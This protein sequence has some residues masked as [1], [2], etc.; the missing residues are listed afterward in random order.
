MCR[1][2][3][4]CTSLHHEAE[5]CYVNSDEQIFPS[6][7]VTDEEHNLSAPITNQNQ[8]AKLNATVIH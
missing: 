7:S 4:T 8:G 3:Y 5:N 6:N 1:Q 2:K